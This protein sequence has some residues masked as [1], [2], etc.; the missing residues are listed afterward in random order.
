MVIL[1]D[2]RYAAAR[3]DECGDRDELTTIFTGCGFVWMFLEFVHRP[4]LS[5]KRKRRSSSMELA[6]RPVTI[7]VYSQLRVTNT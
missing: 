3:I 1:A 2:V 7:K 5:R 6:R 4:R